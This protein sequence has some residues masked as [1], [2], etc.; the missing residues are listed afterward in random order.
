MILKDRGWCLE[1]NRLSEMECKGR[2]CNKCLE[3]RKPKLL[4]NITVYH[5]VEDTHSKRGI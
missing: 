4:D 3:K 1:N 2:K 5:E